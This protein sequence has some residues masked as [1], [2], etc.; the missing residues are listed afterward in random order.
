[1]HNKYT[2]KM[3]INTM[4]PMH[5]NTTPPGENKREDKATRRQTRYEKWKRSQKSKSGWASWWCCC[6]I[7][8]TPTS[9]NK[10]LDTTPLTP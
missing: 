4:N 10:N 8:P 2:D 5:T 1:M 6:L 9:E 3:V 7:Q